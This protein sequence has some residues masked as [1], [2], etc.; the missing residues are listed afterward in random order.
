MSLDMTRTPQPVRILLVDD[1]RAI[2]AIVRRVVELI[3]YAHLDLRTAASGQSALDLLDHFTPDLVITDWHMPGVS[4]VELLQAVR[5]GGNIDTAVGF[6]TT[7][8][9]PRMVADAK[10]YGASFYVNKPF[11]NAKLIAEITRVVPLQ[12]RPEQPDAVVQSPGAPAVRQ[13][14]VG[15]DS[16]FDAQDGDVAVLERPPA[17]PPSRPP[18]GGGP[19]RPA[20]P[21]AVATR[22]VYSAA[23][24]A[25]DLVP[26][27]AARALVG[28]AMGKT[29]FRLTREGAT[30]PKQLGLRN[31]VVL[32]GTPEHPALA[33]AIV[34]ATAVC[35]LGGT[36]AG[37]MASA[38]RNAAS[39]GRPSL[40]MV[41]KC[42][43]LFEQA[44]PM[45]AHAVA[46]AQL[47]VTSHELVPQDM[48][49]HRRLFDMALSR[50][51]FGI[52]VTSLGDGRV[53]FVLAR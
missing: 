45:L 14:V 32:Y 17:A 5:R 41:E 20:G 47:Q 18:A 25:A 53:G 24:L 13:A 9:T 28:G 26:E 51:D 29:A 15:S 44:A 8:A 16:G 42:L 34:D 21:P 35:M 1:S 19:D 43:A 27:A 23:T 4:G 46:P 3:G 36:A 49:E 30:T 39:A 50:S 6:I 40:V 52:S 31:L 38:V 10:R 22:P 7:E 11:D 2:L 48:G 12:G 37:L 33:A